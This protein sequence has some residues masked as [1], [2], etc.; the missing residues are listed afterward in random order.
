MT[1]PD[2][3]WDDSFARHFQSFAADGLVPARVIL[4]HKHAYELL[5][6]D[7]EFSA[8]CTGRLLHHALG[9]GAALAGVRADL[10]AIG[11][12]VAVRPRPTS[13]ALPSGE[14]PIADIHAVLPRRTKAA[15]PRRIAN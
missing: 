11:D 15:T 13:G 14:R 1:L 10:P 3:G 2:L 6:A 9:E 12:W 5:G 4:E 8:V 7:G